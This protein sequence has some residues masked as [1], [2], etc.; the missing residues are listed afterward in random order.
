VNSN[1]IA[2][3]AALAR[4]AALGVAPALVATAARAQA[5]AWPKARNITL[6][7]GYPPGGATDVVGRTIA[8]AL[9]ARLGTS[10]TVENL[11]GAGGTIAAQKVVR[12]APDGYTLLLG[13]CTEVSIARMV[14][15]AIRY[16]GETDLTH[17][18][19]VGTTPLVWVAGSRVGV[20][21]AREAADLITQ[22]KEKYAYASTGVGTQQHIAGA[23]INH[24]LG[25]QMRH[26]P[27]RGGAQVVTDML[28]GQV[29]FSVFSL[30]SVLPHLESGALVALGVGAP[31]RLKEAP[32][33]PSL[34]ETPQF[35]DMNLGIWYGLFGPAQMPEPIAAALNPALGEVLVTRDTS[36]RLIKAGVT[37]KVM[38]QAET[39]RYIAEDARRVRS[40]IAAIPGIDK[41]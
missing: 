3:R 23:Y 26:V 4:L 2:R 9:A 5:P 25:A 18:G 40:I 10:V 41:G 30:P 1:Y 39:T 17:L 35:K 8:D 37:P 20:K 29:E 7:V 15:P 34:A 24:S 11:G 38:S 32:N 16:N 19:L 28:G 22:N 27:Y 14:N 13:A 21:T 36:T 31:E 12:A 6:V 33:I